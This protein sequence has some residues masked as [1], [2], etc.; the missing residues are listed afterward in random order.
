MLRPNNLRCEYLVNPLGLDV[1]SPRLS[2]ILDAADSLRRGIRQTAYRICVAKSVQAL[3][4]GKPLVWDTGKVR[5]SSMNQIAYAGEAL[6]SGAA[7]FWR[8]QVWDEKN[9]PSDWSEPASWSMGLL[10]ES[11]WSAKW[12]E[13]PGAREPYQLYP[14]PLLR[15]EFV[16]SQPVR[17]ATVFVTALGLYELR[18]NGAKVGSQVL[19]PEWT[20]YHK[21]VQ[22]QTYEVTTQI[23]QGANALGAILAD[24]WYAGRLGLQGPAAPPTPILYGTKPAFLLQLHLELEDGSVQ[25]VVSDG[26]W[27]CTLEG[28]IRSTSLLGGEHIDARKE[29]NGWDSPGFQHEA[30][31]HVRVRRAAGTALVAQKNEAIRLTR[32]LQPAAVTEPSPGV[33]IV[34]MG[35]NMV[36]W[37]RLKVMAPMGATITLRHAE[38]LN[39]DGT[40]YRENLRLKG[41]IDGQ[42]DCYTAAGHGVETFEPR[43]TYHGFRYVE[44]TG[45]VSPPALTDVL[46]CV[47]HSDSPMAGGLACSDPA[48]TKLFENIVWTQRGNMHS[49]PTDCPQRD[50]RLGWSGDAQVYSQTAIFSMDMAAFFTKWMQDV[51][52]AQ[53]RDG[54]FPDFAP[55]PYEPEVK[56]SGNPG[57]ADVGVVIPWRL[58]TNYGDTRMLLEN[59]TAAKRW[60]EFIHRHNPDLIWKNRR[61]CTIEYGD[62]LNGDTLILEKY[63]RSGGE[64]PRGVYATAFFAH[65]TDLLART[66]TVLGKTAEARKYGQLLA[67]IKKAFVTAFV[68]DD[69]RVEGD[70]QA[71]Y[72]LALAFDL[73]P[74]K[75]RPLATEKMVNAVEAYQGRIS[76]GIQSTLRLMLALSRFGRDDIAWKLMTNREIPSWLYMVDHGGTTVWE[77]WDGWVEGRGFQSP[78]MNSFN[79]Y[80][81]G[82][83]GE[84]MMRMMVGINDDPSRPG[85]ERI[86][87]HPR[88]PPEEISALTWAEGHYDSIR[89]RISCRWERTKE[90]ITVSVEIPAN[91]TATV[92][93]P[94]SASKH[95]TESKRPINQA[96]GIKILGQRD[97]S[98]VLAVGS[99]C[100]DFSIKK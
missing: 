66:A 50:E 70:T 58:Y 23:R 33:Y 13:A 68:G 95:V 10:N 47:V 62:W 34:D 65:S 8:V 21:R 69:G 85:F 84:W 93:L 30:W 38:V 96:P 91:A 43:F 20:D 73:L 81:I 77:R 39:P 16:L 98:L 56:F 72:A 35:Q 52:D 17:R 99:G 78:G 11:D 12:I 6:V 25:R 54:R 3:E 41:Y 44:I 29:F 97:N 100:Y 36:G 32:E 94:A 45:L 49:V 88:I 76:T 24:G 61:S 19:A 4:S 31:S 37:C 63:P 2:W 27:H 79:H 46:G 7:Y 40:L 60:V 64:V 22:Y 53:T 71:G 28:P 83:V 9:K 48:L 57:W 5:S 15:R 74:E 51:R 67:G 1:E 80:A 82:A 59:F 18:L 26:N 89:G 42:V 86:I 90:R 92:Y 14:S 75:L 55:H 87:I